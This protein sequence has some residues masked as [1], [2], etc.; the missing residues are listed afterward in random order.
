M[1]STRGTSSNDEV[2]QAFVVLVMSFEHIFSVLRKLYYTDPSTTK[3]KFI[4]LHCVTILLHVHNAGFL[5]EHGVTHKR[6]IIILSLLLLR[7][8]QAMLDSN[9][10]TSILHDGPP[11][12]VTT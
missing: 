5:D 9:K 4:F 6:N 10:P 8:M 2:T 1:N 11:P 12:A 3:A 7:L